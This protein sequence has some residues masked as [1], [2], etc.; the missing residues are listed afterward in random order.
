MSNSFTK[1]ILVTGGCGFIGSNY[2]NKFVLQHPEY[3]FINIDCLT[4]AGKTS[5]VIISNYSNYIFEK[6]DIRDVESL[7][8]VFKSYTPTD[9]IHFAAESHVDVS[10]SNPSLFV[11][12]NIVGTHN[13]LRLAKQYK[14]NRFHQIST[15]EV[16]GSLDS[17]DLPAFTKDS[18]IAPNSPYSASKAAADV[19]VRVYNKTFGLDTTITRCSNN[20]GSYQD[21]TKLIPKAILNLLNN[22]KVPVYGKGDNIR[23]WI[24]VEDH[25]DA[26]DLV[27]H[28]GKSGAIYNIG[29]GTELQNIIL[30][31]KLADLTGRTGDC[32]EFVT[33]RK[34]HD[35]RYAIDNSEIEEELGWKPVVSLEKGL[36][37]TIEFYKKAQ[38]S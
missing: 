24:Y 4:Y 17:K 9:I 37:Q 23:D 5:N 13:L 1:K 30:V 29:G 19:L 22:Q 31:K 35:F 10:I 18:P 33:D 25:I 2:L 26:I 12:S 15:D 27:F 16:Y 3:Q 34:G 8:K 38:P 11:E 28:K 36:E 21:E 6:V 14:I 20:Y 7:E 32:V